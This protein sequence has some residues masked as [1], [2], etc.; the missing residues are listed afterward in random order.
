MSSTPVLQRSLTSHKI[1]H[2]N[3]IID[4]MNLKSTTVLVELVY[5]ENNLWL[6]HYFNIDENG[7]RT[8]EQKYITE[9]VDKYSQFGVSLL[10]A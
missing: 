1:S 3:F 8:L 4:S 5:K 9:D 7:N 10:P 6:A 2:A